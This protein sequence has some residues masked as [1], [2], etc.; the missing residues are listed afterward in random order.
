MSQSA[1]AFVLAHPAVST[2]IPGAKTPQQVADNVGA[3]EHKL[4]EDEILRLRQ[5]LE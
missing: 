2:A 5:A 4:T 1:L 3:A